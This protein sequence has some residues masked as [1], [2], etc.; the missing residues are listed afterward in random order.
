MRSFCKIALSIAML[1]LF[2]LF[3]PI[4]FVGFAVQSARMKP[5]DEKKHAL[6]MRCANGHRVVVL[7]RD[8]QEYQRLFPKVVKLVLEYGN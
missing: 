7:Y 6:M 8:E 4:L 1:F 5:R 3:A 2:W